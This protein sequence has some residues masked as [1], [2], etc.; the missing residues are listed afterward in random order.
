MKHIKT[1]LILSMLLALTTI[2]S[3]ASLNWEDISGQAGEFIN[4][5]ENKPIELG[6]VGSLING[7]S[8]ILVTIGVTVVLAG[9]LIIGIKYM[10]ATPEEAAKIKTKLVGLVIAGIVIIASYGI[11]QLA[12]LFFTGASVN[13]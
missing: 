5:G 10:T 7:L 11:W 1:I 9:I 13:G 3:Y 2:P 6:D 12:Y 8:G 4:R